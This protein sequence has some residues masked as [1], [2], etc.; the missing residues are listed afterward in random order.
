MITQ[1]PVKPC[2]NC[3]VMDLHKPTLVQALH[4][5]A[6]LLS[7]EW[8]GVFKHSATGRATGQMSA[9]FPTAFSTRD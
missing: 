3:W 4:Q 9:M 7:G 6:Y 8:E 5:E 1:R 2:L